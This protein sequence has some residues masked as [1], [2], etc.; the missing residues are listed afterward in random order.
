MSDIENRYEE[1]DAVPRELIPETNLLS[2]NLW[3][4]M[5]AVFGHGVIFYGLLAGVV[6]FLIT[7]IN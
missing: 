2:Q 1:I 7:R 6:F 5:W 4:R 3:K